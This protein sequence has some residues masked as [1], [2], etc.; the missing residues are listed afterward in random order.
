MLRDDEL[1]TTNI[2]DFKY[3]DNVYDIYFTRDLYKQFAIFYFYDKKTL[4]KFKV[5]M[6]NCIDIGFPAVSTFK[7]INMLSTLFYDK[8][9]DSWK[10]LFQ[11]IS[12]VEKL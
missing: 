3:G 5:I 12:L 4:N 11:W 9:M 10:V 6:R 1:K 7:G 8:G 2:F